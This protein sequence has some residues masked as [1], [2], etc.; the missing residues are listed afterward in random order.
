LDDCL[1]YGDRIPLS[2][3]ELAYKSIQ[4]TN[5]SSHSLLDMSHDLFHMVFHSNEM[6]M[7]IIS[8]EDTPWDDGHHSSI[9]FLEP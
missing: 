9:L 4:S 6:I 8:M 3:M 7:T 2:L 1:S 5:P